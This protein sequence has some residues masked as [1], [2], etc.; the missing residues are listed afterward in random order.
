M[1][2]VPQLAFDRQLMVQTEHDTP[3]N[4][5]EAA[6]ITLAAVENYSHVIRWA[7]VSYDG[8]PTGGKLTITRGSDVETIYLTAGGPQF[9]PLDLVA[10]ENQAVTIALAEGGDGV[11]GSLSVGYV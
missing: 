7:R 9:I 3:A 2:P 4:A 8:D 5:N 11:K 10:A 6:S 1:P